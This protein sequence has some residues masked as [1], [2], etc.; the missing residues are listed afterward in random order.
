MLQIR[1]LERILE[2]LYGGY[3]TGYYVGLTGSAAI[4]AS[5]YEVNNEK[6]ATSS[7]VPITS[8]VAVLTMERVS[9]HVNW[10]LHIASIKP[11]IY[12]QVR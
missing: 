5:S 9:Q 11:Y 12:L 3:I 7:A 1:Y 8:I 6:E 10:Q 2:C 4:F